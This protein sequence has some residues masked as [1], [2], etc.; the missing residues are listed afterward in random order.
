MTGLVSRFESISRKHALFALA[1][2]VC[3]I[4]GGVTL[5]FTAPLRGP[6]AV[7]SAN[8]EGDAALYKAIA[9]RVRAGETYY[10]AAAD[11]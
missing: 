1:A 3:L 11:E 4:L 6:E 5:G 7:T 10:A 2:L 8:G 9:D